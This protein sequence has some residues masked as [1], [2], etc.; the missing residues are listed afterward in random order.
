MLGVV[1]VVAAVVKLKSGD[2]RTRTAAAKT[3]IKREK[4]RKSPDINMARK[5]EVKIRQEKK[6]SLR[7]GK[8]KKRKREVHSE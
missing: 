7:R 8:F 3:R 5:F 2:S 1:I 6:E 4:K